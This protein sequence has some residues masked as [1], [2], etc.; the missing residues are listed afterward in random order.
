MKLR[1]M[2]EAQRMF[3]SVKESQTQGHDCNLGHKMAEMGYELKI[4]MPINL[5]KCSAVKAKILH[6]SQRQYDL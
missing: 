6:G 5:H 3:V 1:Q 4:L 2:V